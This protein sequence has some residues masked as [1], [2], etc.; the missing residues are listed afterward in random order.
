MRVQNSPSAD[1]VAG[2]ALE[3]A[4]VKLSATDH[5]VGPAC[6]AIVLN[7]EASLLDI[8]FRSGFCETD[9]MIFAQEIQVAFSIRERALA[10]AAVSPNPPASLKLDTGQDISRET[11]EKTVHYATEIARA[12]NLPLEDVECIKQASMLHDL[13]KIGISEKI[14]LKKAK[15]TQKEYE[16][17]K[18]HPQIAVDI[19]RPIQ[20]LHDL[21]PLIFYHHERW[22]GKGYPSGLKNEEIPLGARIISIADV[23]QALMS[24]RSY[25]K[26]YPKHEVV[27]IIKKGKGSQFDPKIVDVFLKILER[28]E[29]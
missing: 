7:G 9:R 2:E 18:K 28:E 27:D 23:Y 3:V 26:A 4:D 25:R 16:E 12:L 19:L 8:T 13:G 1:I 17:I 5:R 14:L 11:V 10:H 15:L 22:D 21:I 20:F 29:E 24:D 6:L